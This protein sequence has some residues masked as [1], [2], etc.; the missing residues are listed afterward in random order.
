M[1]HAF[2][3]P[4]EADASEM[5]DQDQA[6]GTS[7]FCAQKVDGRLSSF[8]GRTTLGGEISGAFGGEQI[9]V[10]AAGNIMLVGKLL[11]AA[12]HEQ[13]VRTAQHPERERD[14]VFNQ[15]DPSHRA[16]SE[17]APIHNTGV[18]LYMPLG[19]QAGASTSIESGI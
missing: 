1:G 6:T 19:S 9:L 5:I 18:K 15:F 2:A 13:H 4:G 3:V 12:P 11:G 7:G 8:L 14:R 10:G 16:D 17:R